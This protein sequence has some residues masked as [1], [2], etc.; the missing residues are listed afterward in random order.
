HPFLF[1]KNEILKDYIREGGNYI[2]Q[3]N[4]AR[5]SWP[6]T[7]GPYP[8]GIS[9]VRVT[10]EQAPVRLLVPEHAVFNF[11]NK[12]T[13][14]DFEGWIQERGIYFATNLDSAF[15]APLAM[16]DPGETEEKG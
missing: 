14:K 15:V 5:Q 7:V 16:K 6:V 11:P 4:T 12:I 10:D 8:F 1:Q 2:V 9:R 3:Y 13:Q